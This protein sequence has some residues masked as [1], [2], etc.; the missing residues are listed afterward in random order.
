M[1]AID[2][3]LKYTI[4][5]Y[6]I[7]RIPVAVLIQKIKRVLFN[8]LYEYFERNNIL[9]QHQY[10]FRKN[11]STECAAMELIDRVANLLE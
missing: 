11:H 8:Q 4:L 9:T 3:S 6:L 2:F 1:Y 5:S 10:G 7:D